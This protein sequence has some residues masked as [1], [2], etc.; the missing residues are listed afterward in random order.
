MIEPK[1]SFM[2][3]SPQT[4]NKDKSEVQVLNSP[5]SL[6]SLDSLDYKRLSQ[7]QWSANPCGAH[8][9]KEYASGTREYFD[10]IEDYRYR[11][12]APWMREVIGFNR[13]AGKILLEVG[14]GTG[15]DLLQFARGGAMVA[16]VDLTPRSIEIA[17]QRFAVYGQLGEF[18]EGD[19]ENLQ[20]ADNSF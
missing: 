17:R 14:C 12:Y 19:A 10:A 11:V 6:D 8:V 16:G 5:D 18:A 7:E 4:R 20:F 2:S 15:T 3:V 13:Y 1:N 9:G